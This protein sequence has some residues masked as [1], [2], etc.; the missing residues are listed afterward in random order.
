MLWP[1][2]SEPDVAR[3]RSPRRWGRASSLPQPGH[4]R[5][6]ALALSVLV[7]VVTAGCAGSPDGP[8]SGQG[9]V[10]T[11]TPAPSMTVSA[12]PSGS[13]SPLPDPPP[14][15]ITYLALGDS[16]VYGAPADCGGCTTYPYLVRDQLA[17]RTGKTVALLDGS[18]HNRLTAVGLVNELRTGS[19][20]DSDPSLPVRITGRTPRQAVAAADL[21]T[22]TVSAN[23]IP[24]YQ[25]LD[26]CGTHYDK[27]C[28]KDVQQ[29]F[30]T[31][32]DRALSEIAKIRAGKK[33]TVLVTTFYNDLLT[34]SDYDP[35][36]FFTAEQV[37]RGPGQAREFLDT[38]NDAICSVSR[39]HGARCADTYHSINGPTGRRPLPAGFFT[40]EAGDLNQGGQIAFAATIMKIGLAPRSL[41]P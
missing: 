16:N 4:G 21:I 37:A 10:P 6:S 34:G 2:S 13:A 19:W 36:A 14:A 28:L 30:A 26:T 1:V 12:E 3:R 8:G 5:H 38:W 40:P 25:P 20:Q 17:R 29:P 33:T 7:L 23:S 18:Q 27:A 35:S 32:L 11:T 31:A 24:W 39:R 15:D 41:T 22:I 9:D